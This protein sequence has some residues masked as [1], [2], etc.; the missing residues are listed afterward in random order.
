MSICLSSE[1]RTSTS[2]S[3]FLLY[4]ILLIFRCRVLHLF[5]FYF[6]LK[7]NFNVLFRATKNLKTSIRVILLLYFEI[8]IAR[9]NLYIQLT[10][11]YLFPFARNF[12]NAFYESFNKRNDKFFVVYIFCGINYIFL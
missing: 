9:L 3:H 6:F 1:R 11:Y 2:A 10:C 5:Y 12:M 8:I 7:Q 4:Y